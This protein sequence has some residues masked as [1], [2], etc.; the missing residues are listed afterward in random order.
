MPYRV[1][2]KI[3]GGALENF[4]CAKR[5]PPIKPVANP[6]APIDSPDELRLD[7][8][9]RLHRI[10]SATSP[11]RLSQI[12]EVS[13]NVDCREGAV[14]IVRA[15][16]ERKVYGE[17]E[18][19]SGRLAKVV[20]GNILAGV[21]GAR[22]ALHGYMGQVPATCKVG[23]VIHLLN[24][25]GVMGTCT[26]ASNAL[27]AP[28]PCQVIGQA[29][30]NGE[31]LNIKNFGLPPC[32]SLSADGPPLLLVMGTCM[33][34]GKTYAAGEIIRLLSFSGVRIAAGKLSGVAALRDTLAMSD[35]GAISTG[36]FLECGLPSTVN[37]QN[38]DA[39]ARAVISKLEKASPELIVLEL[40]DGVIGGYHLDSI[41][42]DPS[43]LRRTKARVLCAN[44]LVGAWGGVKFLDP[45][46]HAPQVVSGPVT[47][48]DVGTNYITG[49]MNIPCFNARNQPVKLAQAMSDIVG[50]GTE[51]RE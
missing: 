30:R 29:M 14:M 50:L 18:L 38:L 2:S 5:C 3:G 45:L 9:V 7:R 23:D 27:G 42:K 21:L 40:G 48:N 36:S 51:V 35:N 25:G 31:L 39:V 11:A 20:S 24:I 41:L 22:Q 10:G 19:P 13:E 33:N 46:G 34:S 49:Q 16:G 17:M 6:A 28:I 12:V 32:D 15:L 44:D 8:K 1:A 4:L 37:E 26:S 47:D 43:I